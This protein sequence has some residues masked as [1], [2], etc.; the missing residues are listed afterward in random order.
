MKRFLAVL[1]MV[2]LV[3]GFAAAQAQPGGTLYVSVKSAELKSGTGHFSN[4]KGHLDLGDQVTV[5]QVNG[6][7][8]EVRSV[9]NSSL[10]GWTSSANFST[11]PV[12]A[13]ASS[14]ATAREVALAGKGLTREVEQE[15]KKQ[16]Q[17][18]NYADVDKVEAITVNNA[19]L[20]RFLDE[21]RLKT[22][23]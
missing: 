14:T 12:I 6:K 4:T 22:G 10:T 2:F 18:L 3:A 5:V 20:K 23:E 21:G 15:Y 8:I 7:N 19:E 9:K 1:C 16:Q 17:N 13:G 11:R